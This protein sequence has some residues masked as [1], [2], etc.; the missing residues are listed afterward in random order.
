MR[1]KLCEVWPIYVM[2][3]HLSLYLD[4]TFYDADATALKRFYSVCLDR[5]LHA[6]GWNYRTT[7]C[8]HALGPVAPLVSVMNM[9]WWHPEHESSLNGLMSINCMLWSSQ[10]LDLDP[11]KY[12]WEILECEVIIHSPAPSSKQKHC[13]NLILKTWLSLQYSVRVNLF[14]SALKLF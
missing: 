12:L 4:G 13:V 3:L 11:I 1:E 9:L 2:C 8:W 7:F 10:S 6:V 5:S 14:Q